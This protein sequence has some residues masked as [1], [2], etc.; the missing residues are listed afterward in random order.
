MAEALAVVALLS[1]MLPAAANNGT[2]WTTLPSMPAARSD[3]ASAAAPCPSGQTGTCLYAIG[4]VSGTGESPQYSAVVESYNPT[5]NA[6]S[7]VAPLRTARVLLAA[8]AARC[9]AGQSGTC[10]YAV[11]GANAA[12][13]L[14]TAEPYNPATNAWSTL[15][16]MNVP[17]SALGAATAA[18][19][20]GHT[21][22]CVYTVSGR[23]VPDGPFAVS[24]DT[25]EFHNPA[26]NAWSPLAP[27]PAARYKAG[28]TAATCPPGQS[29]TCVYA[30]GGLA[31]VGTSGNVYSYNPASNHLDGPALDAHAPG[32][33]RRHEHAVPARDRRHLRPCLR[34]IRRHRRLS[35]ARSPRPPGALAGLQHERRRSP[36]TAGSGGAVVDEPAPADRRQ[37]CRITSPRGS[38]R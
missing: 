20:P 12:S 17:R 13:P 19:P 15:S 14:G 29:G 26:T 11:G 6:W 38:W 37:E 33:L 21:G 36:R 23:A 25:V 5:T 35:H 32:R 9:P 18:C 28:V 4:G 2:I 31:A 16:P 7:T 34:R 1:A 22:T 10:V 3:V 24:V 8:T 30:L 27:L